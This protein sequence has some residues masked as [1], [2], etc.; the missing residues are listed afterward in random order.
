MKKTIL[1]AVVLAVIVSLFLTGCMQESPAEPEL[2]NDCICTMEYA[3]VCS[4]EGD[5]YSN[6]CFAECDEVEIAHQGEC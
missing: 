5:T 1:I 2:I 6:S 4:V 3:P